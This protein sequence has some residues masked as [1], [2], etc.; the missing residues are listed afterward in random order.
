[1][2]GRS[3][4]PGSAD[5]PAVQAL[6]AWRIHN[7]I[8]LFLLEK[9]PAAGLDA[10]P[11]ESRGRTVARQLKHLTDVREGWIHYHR[12]GQRPKRDKAS[13][14]Q[15][16]RAQLRAAMKRSGKAVEAML[17]ES[18]AGE[19]KVRAFGAEPLRW[20]SYLIS[21]ESH[22]RGSIT[23]AL[24]QNGMRLPESVAIQGLWGKWIWGR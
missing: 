10:V 3:A 24:K 9:I 6:N 15:P 4:A 19:A 7:E 20:V 23:L 11:L 14:R 17:R 21:H 2:G 8:N 16:T 13:S 12:T 18:L 5:A 1:M 22:H